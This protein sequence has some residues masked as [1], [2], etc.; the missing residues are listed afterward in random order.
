MIRDLLDFYTIA[1]PGWP[2]MNVMVYGLLLTMCCVYA[3]WR[4]GVPERIGTAI[5]AAGS[6]LTVAAISGPAVSFRSV[7]VGVLIV[8]L[9]CI[10]AFVLLALRAERFWP[11]W[12]AAFQIVG[13]AGHLVKFADPDTIRRV[14]AFLLAIWS[15]PILL[16]LFVGTWRHQKRLARFGIDRSWSREKA[17]S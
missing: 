9:L 5:L 17:V 4:G 8:D 10:V 2:P 16:F 14:Y 15:Y 1:R 13:T 7:E 12:V 11:L 3:L 6:L